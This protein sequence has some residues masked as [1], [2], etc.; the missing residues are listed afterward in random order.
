MMPCEHV[1]AQPQLM[2][3]RH[4]GFPTPLHRQKPQG[5]EVF[6]PS[7]NASRQSS[8]VTARTRVPRSSFLACRPQPKTQPNPTAR[9]EPWTRASP[10][11]QPRRK[12]RKTP[13]DCARRRRNHRTPHRTAPRAG[14]GRAHGIV[15]LYVFSTTSIYPSRGRKDAQRNQRPRVALLSL[16]QSRLLCPCR[17][18]LPWRGAGAAWRGR[19][20][21]P[22]RA[23]GRRRAEQRRAA[24]WP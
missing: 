19:G 21:A 5:S 17:Q 4:L 7:P 12:T 9:A 6:F 20:A 8:V 23:C 1:S 10:R 18:T 3:V 24:E 11:T 16:S 2:S 13:R 22:R 15:A 14:S